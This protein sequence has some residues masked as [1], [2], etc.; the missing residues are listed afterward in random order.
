MSRGIPSIRMFRVLPFFNV[1]EIY[2]S[3][4]DVNDADSLFRRISEDRK[5]I[6]FSDYTIGPKTPPDP[7]IP[8]DFIEMLIDY[9]IQSCDLGWI[10]NQGVCRSLR[11]TLDNVQRQLEQGRI[12]SAANNLQ[13]FLN[14]VEALKDVQLSSEAYAL[15]RFNGEYLLRKLLEE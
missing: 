10:E 7:F 1:D 15:L 2:P 5:N 4:F 14:E 9:K 8:L 12:Q 11:A 6:A 13:A 3:E